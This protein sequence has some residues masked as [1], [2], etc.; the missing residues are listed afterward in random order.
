MIPITVWFIFT[1]FAA[2]PGN[3]FIFWDNFNDGFNGCSFVWAVTIWILRATAT[4]A[5]GVSTL[6]YS[7]YKWFFLK[8]FNFLHIHVQ[9]IQEINKIYFSLF[10]ILLAMKK[11][12]LISYLIILFV[13]LVPVNI[14]LLSI[15]NTH[16]VV[17]LIMM[18]LIEF[19]V[20]AA[21]IVGVDKK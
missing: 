2:T 16:G 6:I 13:L 10:K 15:Q 14:G 18:I 20:V 8:Y 1:V 3:G 17:S 12:K 19:L 11:N 4:S 21:L 5:P 7:Y 9:F